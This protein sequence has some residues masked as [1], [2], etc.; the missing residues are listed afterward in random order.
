MLEGRGK[1]S[2]ECVGGAELSTCGSTREWIR[3]RTG[4]AAVCHPPKG[5]RCSDGRTG[6]LASAH[7]GSSCHGTGARQ[8]H[9]TASRR[10]G[11]HGCRVHCGPRRLRRGDESRIAIE[12]IVTANMPWDAF[13][14][15][16]RTTAMASIGREAALRLTRRAGRG[17]SSESGRHAVGGHADSAGPFV[18]TEVDAGRE[19][20]PDR[21]R[22]PSPPTW[23]GHP[24]ILDSANGGGGG[25]A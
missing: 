6:S 21:C 23:V 11:L 19:P 4:L 17:S 2:I 9:P 1:Q 18:W 15:G 8:L 12:G 22:D 24:A 16:V 20:D 13:T 5:P 7:P 10:A 25:E 3:R 14:R